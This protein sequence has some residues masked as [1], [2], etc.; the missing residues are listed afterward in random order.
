MDLVI[1]NLLLLKETELAYLFKTLDNQSQLWV[2]KSL[3]QSYFVENDNS[4]SI[5]V[6]ELIAIKKQWV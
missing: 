6:L 5:E 1:L 2:A 4:V 3:V